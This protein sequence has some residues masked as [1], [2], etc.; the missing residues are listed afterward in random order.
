MD[1]APHP[2]R[3]RLLDVEPDLGRFLTDD[4]RAELRALAVPVVHV[5]KGSE[6]SAPGVDRL[7]FGAIV[8]DGMLLQ[9]FRFADHET[10]RPVGP[11]DLL[12]FEEPRTLSFLSPGGRT[13]ISDTR[14]AILGTDFLAAARRWPALIIALHIRSSEQAGRVSA[15]LAICQLS[16]VADRLL[17]MMWLLAESWGRVTPAGVTLPMV[18]THEALG[19]LIGARRPTVSLAVSELIERGA[20]VRQRTGWLILEEVPAPVACASHAEPP[21]L[22]GPAPSPWTAPPSPSPP[23]QQDVASIGSEMLATLDRLRTDL[24]ATQERAGST[25]A[26]ARRG[27]ERVQRSRERRAGRAVTR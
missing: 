22:H 10:M 6:I 21:V 17:A 14:L 4:E 18:V 9:R 12:A 25:I 19:A 23:R 8:L 20:I 24:R 15:Q 2:R 1:A 13:A 27:R 3:V 5:L 26:N 16:R 11:G 7:A